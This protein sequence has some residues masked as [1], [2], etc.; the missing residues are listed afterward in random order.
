MIPED[1]KKE[2]AAV[3]PHRLTLIQDSHLSPEKLV[4]N[5]LEEVAVPLE[6][7]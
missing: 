7:L 5:M 2:A 3:L 4:A 6:K 1:V